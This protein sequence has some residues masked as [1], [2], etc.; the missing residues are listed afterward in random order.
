MDMNYQKL[1]DL[2]FPQVTETPEECE[3]RFP[4]FLDEN[5]AKNPEKCEFFLPSVVAELISE[6]KAD[7]KVL[8]NKDRWYGVTY[9]EDKATVTEAFRRFAEEGIYPKNF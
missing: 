9:K 4:K 6:G 1:A 2:L 8:D 7:V 5:L 3:A